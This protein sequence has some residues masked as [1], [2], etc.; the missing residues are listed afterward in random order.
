MAHAVVRIEQ[1]TASAAEAAERLRLALVAADRP[2]VTA[3]EA[4][5]VSGLPIAL[6]DEALWHLAA[7]LAPRLRVGESGT[8]R[9]T[10]AT[11]ERPR[12]DWRSRLAAWGRRHAGGLKL[13]GLLVVTPPYFL[14][15]ATH[16]VSLAHL[17]GFGPLGLVLRAVGAIAAVPL[18]LLGIG[19]FLQFQLAPVG[20]PVLIGIAVQ[21]LLPGWLSDRE[22]PFA[23]I[24]LLL[25]LVMGV[26][27][28][29]AGYLF[30]RH[31]VFG[32]RNLYGLRLWRMV[33]GTLFGGELTPGD[34]LS[35]EKRLTAL[36]ARRQ[37]VVTAGDLVALFGWTP[38]QAD[39]QMA[40]VLLDYGGE[41]VVTDE[42]AI[43]YRFAALAAAEAPR[44]VDTRPCYEREAHHPAFF[45]APAAFVRSFFALMGIG[46]LGLAMRPDASFWPNWAADGQTSLSD[47]VMSQALGGVPYAAIAIILA[48]RF[49][50]WRRGRAAFEAQQPFRRL[51]KLATDH[52]E[53]RFVKGV[54]TRLLARLGGTI[55]VERTRADGAV[56][57][58]FPAFAAGARAAE[59]LRAEPREA[60]AA[61]VAFDT[62]P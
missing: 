28:S 18:V 45:Q 23:T 5:A 15:V 10:F 60:P 53:G 42:G 14:T 7:E 3:A 19:S 2:D 16:A 46:V 54:P 47:Q 21:T 56:W 26:A 24:L 36:L 58:H 35:D 13:M 22:D 51:V 50:L 40:R 27:W 31:W 44:Q 37:G 62:A 57:V 41:V 33:S 4:A 17:D 49:V 61:G 11:L 9:F 48:A 20:G 6:C 34:D 59:A 8:V 25:T 1:K 55:D 30:Y 52:P 29:V 32:R 12:P 38:E 43:A 39:A